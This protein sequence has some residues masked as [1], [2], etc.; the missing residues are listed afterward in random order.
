M[1]RKSPTPPNVPLAPA[2]DVLRSRQRI[3]SKFIV[4]FAPAHYGLRISVLP[5]STV[6][7]S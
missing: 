6:Q 2:P 5:E 4:R 3:V 1:S 7:K